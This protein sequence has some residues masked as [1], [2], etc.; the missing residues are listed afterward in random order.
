MFCHSF[1]LFCQGKSCQASVQTHRLH[2]L[3]HL[4]KFQF[5]P[6]QKPLSTTSYNPDLYSPLVPH[7]LGTFCFCLLFCFYMFFLANQF[8]RCIFIS[9][10]F[11]SKLYSASVKIQ[12]RSWGSG[13]VGT[14]LAAQTSK[15]W[16]H[17][18]SDARIH[19]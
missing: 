3:W 6:Y 8:H 12:Q 2:F 13:S 5:R 4:K 1:P 14:V 10:Y 16:A 9:H 15:A 19:R 11:T 17:L 7:P 18:S